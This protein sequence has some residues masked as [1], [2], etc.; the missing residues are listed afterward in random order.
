MTRR[1]T[2]AALCAASVFALAACGSDDKGSKDKSSSPTPVNATIASSGK[3]A[4]YTI[5]A[6]IKGGLVTLSVTN[7]DKAPHTPQL[8]RVTGNHSV[9]EALKAINSDSDKTPDWIRAEGGVSQTA[10]GQKGQGT[11]NLPAGQY[12]ITDVGGPGSSGPPPYKAFKVTGGQ[13]GA[14]P[15]T[16]VKITADNPGKDQY[17]WDISGALK[18]GNNVVTFNSKGDDAIHFIGAFKVNG[19]PSLAEIKKGLASNGPPPKFVDQSSFFTTAVLDGGKS[20][21]ASVDLAKPGTYVLFCPLTDRGGGKTHDQ[22]GL[23][24]KITVK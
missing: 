17:K 5:P 4:A 24:T 9:Q 22:E 14:L 10:P 15:S 21:T 19:N 20:A 23:L 8:V 11:M 7:N 2:L 18:P 3:T 6:S 1:L 16:P 12:V 13:D